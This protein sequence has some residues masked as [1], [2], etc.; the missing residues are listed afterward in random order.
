MVALKRTEIIN[1]NRSQRPGKDGNNFIPTKYDKNLKSIS[2]TIISKNFIPSW[3]KTTEYEIWE[4][5]EEKD[6]EDGH[7]WATRAIEIVYWL[8]TR[9][10]G[11]EEERA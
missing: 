4:K 9:V 8:N 11:R 10:E 6:R 5:K 1:L 7:G 2:S 3:C